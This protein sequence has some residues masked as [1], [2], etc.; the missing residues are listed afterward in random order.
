VKKA[1]TETYRLSKTFNAPLKFVY[2]WC[3]DFRPG[4]LKMIG[5]KN[6]RNIIHRSKKRVLWTVVSK[7]SQKGYEGVR[8]VWLKPPNSWHLDTCGDKRE[9]GEYKLTPLAKGRTRLDMRFTVSYDSAKE[10]E[11]RKSWQADARADWDSYGTYLERDYRR[12]LRA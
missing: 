9:L 8:V 2:A 4:D 3:T 10:V 1:F 11:G 6:R 12:S 7:D 5:S